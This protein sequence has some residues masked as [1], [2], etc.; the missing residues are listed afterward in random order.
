MKVLPLPALVQRLDDRLQLLTG[1][2]HDLPERQQ[3]IRATIAWSYGLLAEEEQTLF[4]QLAVFSGGWD[5]AAAEAVCDLNE[6]G[7][8]LNGLSSLVDQS[9][10]QVGELSDDQP[11]FS[12]LETVREFA[13]EC[14]AASGEED[15]LRQRHASQLLALA[16]KAEWELT[17]PNQVRWLE[18]L[19]RE[20]D[21]VRTALRWARD[22]GDTVLG[23]RLAGALWRFWSTR[24]Y[25]SEGRGWLR[26]MLDPASA[27]SDVIPSAQ[28]KA[29]AGAAILAIDQGA[30]DEAA[31][32]CTS[33]IAL[34]RERGERRTLVVAL[35]AQGVLARQQGRPGDALVSHKE[36]LQ[37]AREL[38][39]RTGEGTA[40]N[41]LAR[42][43][44]LAGDT[45]RASA[46][47]E[48]SLA[49]F[50]ELGDIQGLAESLIYMTL[51]AG[52]AGELGRAASLGEE[53]LAHFRALDDTG[54][55]A[56]SLYILGT[57]AAFQGEY[58][59]AMSLQE[60][61]LAL[62]LAR[63]DE[64]N[65]AASRGALGLIALN[66]G[67]HV[68]A[69][70]LLE[71]ALKAARHHD[72]RWGPA[73][74]LTLLGHVELDAGDVE[75][76][77]TLF[78][79]SLTLFQALGNPFYVVWCLE[80]LTR[81]AAAQGHAVNA[82]RLCGAR[83]ALR[84]RR[85]WWFPPACPTAY[86][87]TLATIRAALGDEIFAEARTAGEGAPMEQ[88]VAEALGAI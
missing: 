41:G 25:L 37:L 35:N 52:N 83:D 34:A 86:E 80:G 63:G 60:E 38:G 47:L 66:R 7:D 43:A 4:R 51:Q 28:A 3:T 40:L 59:R 17:G 21:N 26:D 84:S 62:R 48:Q 11:R 54:K 22:S 19:E 71:D 72:D 70:V 1:G 33:S 65:A 5:L 6:Q 77:R 68:R 78:E 44:G 42:A 18:R 45:A 81:V 30:N 36:A 24:G 58:E 20:H 12:M 13:A 29:L 27:N 16:E 74:S 14:L 64:R 79:E 31:T 9:L 85:G 57:V 55:T 50:R 10:L 23:Q 15:P 73:V 75:T 2:P 61:S 39:D 88:T 56:E 67:D 69:R 76:A 46:L 8:L 49:V 82:A 32:L 53:A 87:R